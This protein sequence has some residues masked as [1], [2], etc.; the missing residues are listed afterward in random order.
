MND[1]RESHLRIRFVLITIILV[2]LPCYCTGLA[3]VRF[4]G[5]PQP[6]QPTSTPLWVQP[7]TQTAEAALT[8]IPSFTPF[9]ITP[10]PV[11][12]TP[13]PAETLTPTLPPSVTPTIS[14][15]AIPLPSD[16]PSATPPP[17][18]T[19]L[20]TETLPP[21]VTFTPSPTFP[22]Y[23]VPTDIILTPAIP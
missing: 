3:L 22:A 23:P 2:T 10:T 21:T 18:E 14:P 5:G 1:N 17:T 11:T 8:L 6:E 13:T 16:T 7:A 19:F 12:P 20:P 9:F 4:A 15:T